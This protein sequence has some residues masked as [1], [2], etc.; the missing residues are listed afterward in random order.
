MPSKTDPRPSG[1]TAGDPLVKGQMSRSRGATAAARD[2]YAIESLNRAIDVLSVFTHARPELSL[3]D[4]IAATGLP[5]TTT[6]RILATLVA[7]HLCDQDPVTGHYSVG[8]AMLHFA[9]IR[10]RQAKVRDVAMP[11]MRDIRDELSE[12]VVLSIRHGDYRVHID[13]AE[14]FDQM[15]RMPEP[16]VRV[17]LY[18]GAASKVLLAGMSDL[19]IDSYLTRTPLKQFQKNTLISRTALKR[20]IAMVRRNGYAE[21]RSELIAG[22]AAVAVP[23]RDYT[24]DSVA[25]IDVLTP[26]GR[27]TP[28]FRETSLRLL[29]G[30]ARAISER[31][32][33][34][35]REVRPRL[36]RRR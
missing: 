23:I 31:L 34:S 14:G 7:R 11:V 18:A 35:L 22:C 28:A 19:E 13:A 10:R 2:P 21:S 17:P 8:F 32:G 3:N 36:S 33:L 6:F 5:K 25:V 20:E 29:L 15:R 27:Y 24:G 12:T 9:D 1:R 4:I 16:G 30:G 26:E